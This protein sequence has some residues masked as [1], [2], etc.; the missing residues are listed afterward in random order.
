MHFAKVNDGVVTRVV[1]ADSLEILQSIDP[2]PGRWIQTSYNTRMGVHS[3]GGIPLRKNFASSGFTYD[4][5]L[6]AFIPPKPSPE[7]TILNKD[8]GVW[9]RPSVPDKT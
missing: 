6:D 5:E 9:E 2:T 7:H 8:L 4:Y 1:V 3:E